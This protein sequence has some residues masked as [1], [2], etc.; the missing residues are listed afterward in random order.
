[1]NLK[2]RFFTLLKVFKPK[3]FLTF[4]FYMSFAMIIIAGSRLY[5]LERDFN[6]P[7]DIEH[8][9]IQGLKDKPLEPIYSDVIKIDEEE[10][11]LINRI[12]TAKQ[13]VVVPHTYL[14]QPL[15]DEEIVICRTYDGQNCLPTRRGGKTVN[16]RDLV[17][18]LGF[19]FINSKYILIDPQK[20]SVNILYLVMYVSRED[21]YKSNS[22]NKSVS[23]SST[24]TPVKDIKRAR[25][26]D[27]NQDYISDST[28]SSRV[29]E[30]KKNTTKPKE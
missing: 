16:Y 27:Y 22:R 24:S 5:Q 17:E 2:Q 6:K 13:P 11:V 23:G 8:N 29:D 18:R 10:R 25:S 3:S 26:L 14:P 12:D 15:T 9:I 19:G 1:M 28:D 20:N 21:V 7:I 30:Y 4:V